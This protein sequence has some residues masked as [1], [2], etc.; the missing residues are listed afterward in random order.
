[1]G[2]N[3]AHTLSSTLS[4]QSKRTTFIIIDGQDLYHCRPR[5]LDS[6]K[7]VTPSPGVYP[8]SYTVPGDYKPLVPCQ[9][10]VLVVVSCLCAGFDTVHDQPHCLEDS[11]N[12]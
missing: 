1:M 7:S 11:L 9:V 8:A 2:A 10:S 4:T 6:N 3:R 12:R 5:R